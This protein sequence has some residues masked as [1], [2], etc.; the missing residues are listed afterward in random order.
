[1]KLIQTMMLVDQLKKICSAANAG[2]ASGGA[3]N[4]VRLLL[5][6]DFNSLPDS[7]VFEYL[8]RGFVPADHRDFK[9][10]KYRGTLQKMLGVNN[11]SDNF[12]HAFKVW[13]ISAFCCSKG[14]LLGCG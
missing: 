6:G 2:G 14:A 10:F 9:E 11:L 8:Q 12:S 13:P 7:G 1:M 3:A 5:C 4:P